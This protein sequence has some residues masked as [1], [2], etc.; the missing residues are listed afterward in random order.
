MSSWL[1]ANWMALAALVI[2]AGLAAMKVN[3]WWRGRH[4]VYVVCKSMTRT[5]ASKLGHG[6]SRKSIVAITVTTEGKPISIDRIEFQLMGGAPDPTQ[7]PQIGSVN[8]MAEFRNAEF[9]PTGFGNPFNLADGRSQTWIM[10]LDVPPFD[11]GPFKG[12]MFRGEVLLTTGQSYKS[13]PFWHVPTPVDG[14]PDEA[15]GTVG[16]HL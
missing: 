11:Y 16:D 13:G 7:G 2:S 3:E 14:W 8:G 10:S 1:L 4:R 12:F 15:R 9:P 6:T 5:V